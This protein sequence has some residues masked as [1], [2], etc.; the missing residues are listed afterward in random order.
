MTY[1]VVNLNP[2]NEKEVG[3]KNDEAKSSKF[4]T[5]PVVAGPGTF[6]RTSAWVKCNALDVSGRTEADADENNHKCKQHL[7]DVKHFQSGLG[8]TLYPGRTETRQKKK[9][10]EE[11]QYRP[12]TR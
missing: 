10:S 11:K 7:G 5:W 6:Q 12:C 3:D 1:G 8:S 9:K 4:V 2:G